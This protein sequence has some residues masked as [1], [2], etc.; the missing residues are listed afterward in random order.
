MTTGTHHF[1]SALRAGEYYAHQGFSPS[2]V[3]QKI[4]DGEIAIGPP[5]IKNGQKLLIDKDEGR[6]FIYSP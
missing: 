4:Q 3:A 1:V 6:Y 2:D 5:Q